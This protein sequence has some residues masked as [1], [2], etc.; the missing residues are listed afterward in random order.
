LIVCEGST[1]GQPRNQIHKDDILVFVC[2][3]LILYNRFV[4][5]Q[6]NFVPHLIVAVLE[7]CVLLLLVVA[8]SFLVATMRLN[9]GVVGV[10]F[11]FGLV[12]Q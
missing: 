1:H 3:P 7:W 5:K 12:K 10:N 6:V 4:A 8:E 11:I 9:F 2:Y